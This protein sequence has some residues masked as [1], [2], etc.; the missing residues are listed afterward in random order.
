[1]RNYFQKFNH[2]H[3]F[4]GFLFYK[5]LQQTFYTLHTYKKTQNKGRLKE[6]FRRPVYMISIY[7]IR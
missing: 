7:P 4:T 1:S 6:Y 5:K 2:R 3:V